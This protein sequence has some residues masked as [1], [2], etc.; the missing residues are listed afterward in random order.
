MSDLQNSSDLIKNNA[1]KLQEL[2]INNEIYLESIKKIKYE[3]LE[4]DANTQRQNT[5]IIN[6]LGSLLVKIFFYKYAFIFWLIAY[7]LTYIFCE[8]I[9][10]FL[11]NIGLFLIVFILGKFL[12]DQIGIITSNFL[13][14]K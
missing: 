13:K 3:K 9:I 5:K 2:K 7:I 8:K 11:N 4:N 14:P 10:G 1:E 12:K 6:E